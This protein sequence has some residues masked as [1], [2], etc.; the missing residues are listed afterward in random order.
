[1]LSPFSRDGKMTQQGHELF[2]ENIKLAR[3]FSNKVKCP[4]GFD[5]DDWYQE[6]LSCLVQAVLYYDPEKGKLSTLMFRLVLHKRSWAIGQAKKH[7]HVSLN[8]ISEKADVPVCDMIEDVKA[9]DPSFNIENRDSI[10]NLVNRLSGKRKT[11]CEGILAGKT[12]QQIGKGL[13]ITREAVRQAIK[14]MSDEYGTDDLIARIGRCVDCGGEYSCKISMLN[15]NRNLRCRECKARNK[16]LK[17]K[18]FRW[19][20]KLQ[21]EPTKI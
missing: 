3:F 19:Q 16:Y 11:I 20:N 15:R 9:K 14:R 12:L 2:N 21:G 4:I 17:N 13:G 6:V 8:Y 7:N 1:V 10:D 5:D 18:L